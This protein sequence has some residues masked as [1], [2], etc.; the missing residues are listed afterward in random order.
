MDSDRFYYSQDMGGLVENVHRLEVDPEHGGF[1]DLFG[2]SYPE[3][4]DRI[5]YRNIDRIPAT[6]EAFLEL[7]NHPFPDIREEARDNAIL[8]YKKIRDLNIDKLPELVFEDHSDPEARN[9]NVIRITN[10]CHDRSRPGWMDDKS[11]YHKIKVG[12]NKHYPEQSQEVK[13]ELIA[14]VYD[15]VNFYDEG[16]V[17]DVIHAQIIS[18]IGAGENPTVAVSKYGSPFVT[19]GLWTPQYEDVIRF[20]PP[21]V[22]AQAK[23]MMQPPGYY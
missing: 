23:P 15:A 14:S 20:Y 19:S 12:I 1:R 2:G 6:C 17:D 10:A 22:Q 5:I 8:I 9:R 18:D 13:N 21:T 4:E 16:D 11:L 7:L 3:I